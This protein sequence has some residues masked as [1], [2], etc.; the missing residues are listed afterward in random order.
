MIES[1]MGPPA[2]YAGSNSD[3]QGVGL[4]GHCV[5]C[6]EFGHVAAHP[7][8]GCGDVGCSSH[9]DEETR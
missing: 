6:A 4:P 9:H 8:L 2:N 3:R 5:R 7:D 1:Y